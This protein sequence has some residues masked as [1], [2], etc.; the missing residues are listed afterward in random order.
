M[1][2]C[3]LHYSEN[4]CAVNGMTSYMWIYLLVLDGL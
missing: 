4:R 2:N 3:M 1:Y